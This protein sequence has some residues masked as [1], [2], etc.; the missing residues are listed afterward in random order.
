MVPRVGVLHDIT[1]CT[2]VASHPVGLAPSPP[3]PRR[4]SGPPGRALPCSSRRRV[5]CFGGLRPPPNTNLSQP[6][7]CCLLLPVVVSCPSYPFACPRGPVLPEL[8]FRPHPWNSEQAAPGGRCRE[9][10]LPKRGRRH[11]RVTAR[12]SPRPASIRLVP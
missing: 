2:P 3:I 11:R 9:A 6:S 4:L 7:R 10:M 8:G 12:K 5:A 1:S